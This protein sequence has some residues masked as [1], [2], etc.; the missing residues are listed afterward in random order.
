MFWLFKMPSSGWIHIKEGTHMLQC[1]KYWMRSHLTQT[2]IYYK[3]C[4]I[5]IRFEAVIKSVNTM[6]FTTYEVLYS[7]L[8]DLWRCLCRLEINRQCVYVSLQNLLWCNAFWCIGVHTGWVYFCCCI[9][10][11]DYVLNIVHIIT[12][13]SKW[14][15]IHRNCFID[16]L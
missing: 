15:F 6:N 5:K 12:S 14:R 10:K 16:F 11:Y 13:H 1:H 2:S 4:Y 9:F 3:E 8:K 7:M